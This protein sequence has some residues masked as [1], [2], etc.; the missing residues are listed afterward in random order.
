M[1]RFTAYL[2]AALCCACGTELPGP[3]IYY[4]AEGFSPEELDAI[5]AGVSTWET[6]GYR[7]HPPNEIPDPRP[8]GSYLLTVVADS[9]LETLG[10]AYPWG[11]I[12][13]RADLRLS[14]LAMTAA[15]E[16]GHI[17]V[18]ITGHAPEGCGLMSS[19]ART[20][21]LTDCDLDWICETFGACDR[22]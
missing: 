12:R 17:L 9:E 18:P 3:D 20:A 14:T 19:P 5:E 7:V 15:H 11:E 10:S 21:T 4:R 22:Y 6:L 2:L 16:F 1:C 13:I 8:R